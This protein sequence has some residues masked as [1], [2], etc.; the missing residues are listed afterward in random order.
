[1][2]LETLRHV[3]ER[4]I[5]RVRIFPSEAGRTDIVSNVKARWR[6]GT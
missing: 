6:A 5:E 3:M 4:A 1:M 2:P